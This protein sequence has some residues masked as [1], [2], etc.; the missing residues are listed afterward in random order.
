MAG[1]D[2]KEKLEAASVTNYIYRAM[3]GRYVTNCKEK[4]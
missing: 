1:N 3:D 2:S 4:G